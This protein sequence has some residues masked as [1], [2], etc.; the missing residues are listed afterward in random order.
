MAVAE[1]NLKQAEGYLR[2]AEE[3]WSFVNSH[4]NQSHSLNYA[5]S[6]LEA[7]KKDVER[8]RKLRDDIEDAARREGIPPGYLRDGASPLVRVLGG[9]DGSR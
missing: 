4:T 2:I 7:A 9:C 6:L 3:N 5:R 1:A 8:R